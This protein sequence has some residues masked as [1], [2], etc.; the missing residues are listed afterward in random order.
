MRSALGDSTGGPWGAPHSLTVARED[1]ELE[2]ARLGEPP[3]DGDVA[4]AVRRPLLRDREHLG[5]TVR[6]RGEPPDRGDL[7]VAEPQ[8]LV[9]RAQATAPVHAH[10]PRP[11][12]GLARDGLR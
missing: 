3:E 1:A 11:P 5:R 8:V 6:L 2:R 12:A 9:P 10:G 7:I 4:A